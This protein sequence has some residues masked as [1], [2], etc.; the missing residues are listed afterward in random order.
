[1]FGYTSGP[2]GIRRG[3]IWQSS[4]VSKSD[5]EY[6][7]LDGGVCCYT[8]LDFYPLKNL[9][10]ESDIL[11]ALVDNYELVEE[12]DNYKIYRID[13][14]IDR[15]YYQPSLTKIGTY[16]VNP[17]STVDLMNYVYHPAD[18]KASDYADYRV[19]IPFRIYG[20][21]YKYSE[22]DRSI[23]EAFAKANVT[24]EAA[25]S[26][27]NDVKHI[28]DKYD[29]VSFPSWVGKYTHHP[30]DGEIYNPQVISFEGMK[31][32]YPDEVVKTVQD[33]TYGYVKKSYAI[34]DYGYYKND[35]ISMIQGLKMSTN[36]FKPYTTLPSIHHLSFSTP[37]LNLN[38]EDEK[39]AVKQIIPYPQV[40]KSTFGSDWAY[41]GLEWY[42]T[43]NTSG[44]KTYSIYSVDKDTVGWKKAPAERGTTDFIVDRH[45]D[46]IDVSYSA[47]SLGEGHMSVYSSNDYAKFGYSFKGCIQ[48]FVF[49]T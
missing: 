32:V 25:D 8:G 13:S 35:S 5:K 20:Y 31:N 3:L 14:I 15:Y 9:N 45:I 11:P 2:G 39:N 21:L 19:G 4:G 6:K 22:I 23:S 48:P 38:T 30:D 10:I 7:E 12:G 37:F 28:L 42:K 36:I 29:I 47:I 18:G 40:G 49:K 16:R 34:S 46:T 24:Q 43:V 41:A 26:F 44:G 1:M 33:T 27:Y 17:D